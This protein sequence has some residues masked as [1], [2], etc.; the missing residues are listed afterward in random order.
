ITAIVRSRDEADGHSLGSLDAFCD[1]VEWASTN[2][3][4]VESLT[5]AGALDCFGHRAAVLEG[6]EQAIGAAQKRQKAAA[7]GQM[8]LFG[9]MTEDASFDQG[10]SVLPDVPEADSRQI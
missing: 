8:D 3:R 1:A 9:M 6:L 2:K 4:V 10:P 5:K 7:R